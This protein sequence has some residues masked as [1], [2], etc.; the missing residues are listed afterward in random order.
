MATKKKAAKKTTAKP[1]A[2]AVNA[3]Q[4]FA[5]GTAYLFRL[6]TYAWVG[7]VVA[8][9]D[10][11]IILSEASWVADTGRFTN[12]LASGLESMSLSEIEP[13]GDGVII[14]RGAIVDATP[15]KHSLPKAQK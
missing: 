12:A 8:V 14:G 13:A 5:I 4:P 1:A 15:Y 9:G 10:K 11:E 6:V 3:N 2:K 7:R